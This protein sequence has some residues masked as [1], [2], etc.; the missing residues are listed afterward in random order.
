[1]FL[2]CEKFWRLLIDLEVAKVTERLD[3]GGRSWSNHPGLKGCT[4]S[5]RKTGATHA[6][7]TARR[8]GG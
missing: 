8:A 1:M 7:E 2:A 6:W 4:A 3:Y 5:S